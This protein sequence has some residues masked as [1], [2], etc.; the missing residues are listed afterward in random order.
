MK[1]LQII[2]NAV[3]GWI[4]GLLT[5]GAWRRVWKKAYLQDTLVLWGFG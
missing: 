5:L 1:I 4:A 2:L 3:T